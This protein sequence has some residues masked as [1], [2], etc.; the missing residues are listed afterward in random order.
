M[1][2]LL[3]ST[4]PEILPMYW[5]ATHHSVFKTMPYTHAGSQRNLL[6]E[7]PSPELIQELSNEQQ[8]TSDTPPTFLWHTSED[9][10][11][12]PENSIQFYL[13]CVQAKVPAELHIFE[14]GRHGLGLAKSTPGAAAWPE[15]CRQ[16]MAQRG[17][18]GD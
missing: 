8:V 3:R 14:K 10:A 15:L 6:G 13:A 12:P 11:V 4:Y 17:V 16:W 5:R 2:W 9:T 7:N 18:L 1:I